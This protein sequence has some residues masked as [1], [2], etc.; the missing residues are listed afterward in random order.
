MNE[1]A[2][3]AIERDEQ[4]KLPTPPV[5]Y[6]DIQWFEAGDKSFAFAAKVVGVEGA[7][8]LKLVIFKPNALPVHKCAV[9]HVNST[10]HDQV[11]NPTTY[12]CGSWDYIPGVKIPKEHFE[13]FNQDIERR[14]ENLRKAE[15]AA[16]R[17]AEVFA[18]KQAER[19]G[20]KKAPPEAIP[21]F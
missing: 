4:N 11:N 13:L 6:G 8:R 10:I 16:K 1:V 19:Y 3:S 14:K 17:Q 5:S 2:W 7:G 20:G 9:Y 21:Q 12:R 15:E 18:Q